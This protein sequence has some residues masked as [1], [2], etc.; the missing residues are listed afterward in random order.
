MVSPGVSRVWRSAM[1]STL[2]DV[3]M[4]LYSCR[5]WVGG[6]PPGCLTSPEVVVRW[7]VYM[8]AVSPPGASS[9]R[10]NAASAVS[11]DR[12][13]LAYVTR[14]GVARTPLESPV[15]IPVPWHWT[16]HHA[17]LRAYTSTSSQG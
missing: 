11:P 13:S 10:C 4:V 6:T 3:V 17:A 8:P 9:N 7:S 15:A 2:T 14:A 16:P 5:V 1:A 12:H